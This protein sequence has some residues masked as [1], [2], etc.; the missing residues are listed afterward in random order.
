MKLS[1]AIRLGAM[2]RAQG[3]GRLYTPDTGRTCALGAAADAIGALVVGVG[4]YGFDVVKTKVPIEWFWATKTNVF[5]P[6]HRC[7]Y[8]CRADGIVMHLNDSHE[9]TRERIADWVA[10]I[11]PQEPQ[12]VSETSACGRTDVGCGS[13]VAVLG[14]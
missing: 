6:V 10:T 8:A 12:T 1:E 5:C 9:W 4:E 7:S 14:K 2:L 13:P 3:F 11:E